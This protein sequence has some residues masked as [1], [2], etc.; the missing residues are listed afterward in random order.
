M[1]STMS[2]G[3]PLGFFY[4][5]VLKNDGNVVVWGRNDHGQT[6]VPPG[7]GDTYAI[8]AGYYHAAA[9]AYNPLLNYPVDPSQDL[10]LIANT[11]SADSTNLRNYYLAHR[12]MVGNANTLGI[13]CPT[14]T[15]TWPTRE[16]L[17]NQLVTPVLQWLSQNPTKRPNY[18]VMMYDI[19]SRVHDTNSPENATSASVT[20]HERYPVRHPY[21]THLNMRNYQDCTNYV[22]KLAYFGTNYS[23]QKVYI[24]PSQ[25]VWG[26]A[27]YGNT[28]YV[29][30]DTRVNYSST[31]GRDARDAVLAYGADSNSV[32]YVDALYLDWPSNYSGWPSN[33]VFPS[34]L[35]LGTNVA[36]YMSFGSHGGIWGGALTAEIGGGGFTNGYVSFRGDSGWFLVQTSESFN[37]RWYPYTGDQNCFQD[38]FAPSAF[39]TNGAANNYSHAAAGGVSHTDE[40]HGVDAMNESAV[41]F[42]LW[43]GGRH[44]GICAWRSRRTPLFQATGDPLT[45]R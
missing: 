15:E 28:N 8:S 33:S 27:N 42:G 23:P 12:P 30:D 9:L 14:N 24:S 34:H 43:Q 16:Q 10:L 21:V 32:L 41:Y 11:N 44:F 1:G 13:G 39:S 4:S 6:N 18:V 35:R 3:C 22:N 38:W 31:P 40:P 2:C 45:R 26:G 5:M 7:L 37:G 19:P 17:T 25:G 20:I 29:F 36:G